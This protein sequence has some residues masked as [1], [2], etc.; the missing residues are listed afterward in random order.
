MAFCVMI[1]AG[2]LQQQTLL[3]TV[4]HTLEVETT[5]MSLSDAHSALAHLRALEQSRRPDL[6]IAEGIMPVM[7]GWQLVRAL[8][9]THHS[10][11]PVILVTTSPFDEAVSGAR[12]ISLRVGTAECLTQPVTVDAL[13]AAIRGVIP[14]FMES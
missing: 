10:F 6:I 7:S 14:G 12:A 1:V 13:R 5:V 4:V 9:Y 11:I 8:K 3:R 2:D